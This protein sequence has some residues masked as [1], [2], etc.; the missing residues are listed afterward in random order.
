LLAEAG[1]AG[2]ARKLRL[3]LKILADVG[4]IG[5]P[6]A[7]KSSILAAIS[8]ARPKIADYPFTTLEPVLGVI[9]RGH[10]RLVVA[11]IPGLIKGAHRGAGL[12]L[13]FLKHIERARALV[14]V[15]DGSGD[16]PAGNI[17]TVD[18][19]LA[20]FS[21]GLGVK[22]QLIAVNKLDVPGVRERRRSI[23]A[24]IRRK[25][26]PGRQIMF[27]SAATH[28]GL[29]SLIAALSA[30]VA[31]ASEHDQDAAPTPAEATVL[32]PRPVD[33]RPNVVTEGPGAFRIVHPWAVRLARGSN[34]NDWATRVQYHARLRHLKV[35]QE[36]D[37]LGVR[38]GDKVTVAEWEFVWE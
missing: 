8:A 12:G 13:E 5:L 34:L 35:T 30:A 9:Y 22:P 17:G 11:D 32:R 37:R 36:L 15:V 33:G 1:D 6:N 23:A 27:V 14:H 28:E 26:G 19:E 31:Q 24:S 16:D 29:E 4:L 18:S 10:E 2:E 21:P 38:Q 25:A 7:G 20:S 3:N